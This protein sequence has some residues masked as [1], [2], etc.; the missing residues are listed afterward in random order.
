MQVTAMMVSETTQ[1]WGKE[2]PGSMF[3]EAWE[4]LFFRTYPEKAQIC[5]F[6][7]P[8]PI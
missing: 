3:H 6:Y 8:S 5:S 4:L 2:F 7:Q 1:I